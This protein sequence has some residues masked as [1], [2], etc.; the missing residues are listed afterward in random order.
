M[1]VHSLRSIEEIFVVTAAVETMNGEDVL[2]FSV[3]LRKSY[4]S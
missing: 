1:K 3:V 4:V 2:P